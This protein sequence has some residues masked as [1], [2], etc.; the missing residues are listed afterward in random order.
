MLAKYN[1]TNKTGEYVSFVSDVH[2]KIEVCAQNT[3]SG[4]WYV[5]YV[6]PKSLV[7]VSRPLHAEIAKEF[8][9]RVANN[10]LFTNAP[11]KQLPKWIVK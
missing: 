3:P 4:E 1:G 6:S 7:C 10:I 9:E 11:Y 5:W 8:A 2:P